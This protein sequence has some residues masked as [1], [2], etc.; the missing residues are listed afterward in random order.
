MA[1]CLVMGGIIGDPGGAIF[2]PGHSARIGN[3]LYNGEFL[4]VWSKS[5]A[6]WSTSGKSSRAVVATGKELE[7]PIPRAYLLDLFLLYK[8]GSR[9]YPA[10]DADCAEQKDCRKNKIL[11]NTHIMGNARLFCNAESQT[12][13]LF[14]W[15]FPEGDLPHKRL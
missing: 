13:L 11:H 12:N 2:Q 10:H 8:T 15:R 5:L 9:L 1:G 6:I 3:R 7:L 4:G 14:N